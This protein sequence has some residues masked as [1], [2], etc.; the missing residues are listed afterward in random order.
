MS[1]SQKHVTRKLFRWRS[2]DTSTQSASKRRLR[3][4]SWL[5]YGFVGLGL[6]VLVALA[7]RPTPIPVD[8]GIATTGPL[9]VTID[10]EGQTRVKDR[11]VDRKSV[12]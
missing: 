8:I 12:V 9:Q 6:A 4:P 5:P 10:A 3:I 7:F 2:K 11:Y 1:Q